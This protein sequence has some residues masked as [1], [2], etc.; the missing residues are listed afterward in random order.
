[1]GKTG[2]LC[3]QT[4]LSLYMTI[5]IRT[6]A[7]GDVAALTQLIGLSVRNL[8]AGYYTARQVESALLYVFGIDSQLIRDHTYFVAETE[9]ALAGWGEWSKRNTL[10]GGDQTKAAEDPL[11]DPDLDAARIR[12]FFVHPQ[13]ARR[14]V[15]RR[16]ILACEEAARAGGFRK[17]ELGATLPGQPLYSAMGY[18][19]VEP[20]QL[21]FPDGVLFPLYR[22]SKD[23]P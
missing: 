2:A 18:R 20:I 11:L 23:L 7:P 8:S 21:Q 5:S 6:A 17:L 4:Q 19:I 9:G 13:W 15:G 12:A 14:G 3:K 22:M 10:Y 1:M 16:L